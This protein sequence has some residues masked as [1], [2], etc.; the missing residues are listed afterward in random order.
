MRPF[1]S[2]C[3]MFSK[4]LPNV[5]K[6]VVILMSRGAAIAHR[7]KVSIIIQLEFLSAMSLFC[8]ES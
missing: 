5:L 1:L 4:V 7:R 2:K 6:K 8:T 3:T